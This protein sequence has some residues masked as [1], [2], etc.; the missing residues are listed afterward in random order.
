FNDPAPTEIYPLSLHDALPILVGAARA[1]RGDAQ[2]GPRRA[3]RIASFEKWTSRSTFGA[4]AP[5]GTGR[6]GAVLQGT[7]DTLSFAEVNRLLAASHKTG[8]LRMDA[9]VIA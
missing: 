7:F 5:K 9:G 1:D 4:P 2:R 3:L 8:A 6:E